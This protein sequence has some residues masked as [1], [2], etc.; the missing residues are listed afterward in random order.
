MQKP[1]TV[2]A[3][4]QGGFAAQIVQRLKDAIFSAAALAMNWLTDMPSWRAKTLMLS[5]TELGTRTVNVVSWC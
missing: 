3:F 1:L 2:L 5:C 4:A